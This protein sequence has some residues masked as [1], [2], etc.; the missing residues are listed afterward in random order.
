M[1]PL[2]LRVAGRQPSRH[3]SHTKHPKC[4]SLDFLLLV[5]RPHH[6]YACQRLLYLLLRVVEWGVLCVSGLSCPYRALVNKSLER[7]VVHESHLQPRLHFRQPYH[8]LRRLVH[9]H[10]FHEAH[11]YVPLVKRSRAQSPKLNPKI[12]SCITNCGDIRSCPMFLFLTGNAYG[13]R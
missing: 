12:N 3:L 5:Y 6:A 1:T 13:I 11:L 7:L 4:F 8:V 10:G 9:P 2:S